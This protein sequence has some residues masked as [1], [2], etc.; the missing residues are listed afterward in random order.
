MKEKEKGVE[1][2]EKRRWLICI[3]IWKEKL[4]KSKGNGNDAFS[5]SLSLLNYNAMLTLTR[6]VKE[7]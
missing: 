4:S 6:A 1:D 3:L 5:L 2:N 7:H